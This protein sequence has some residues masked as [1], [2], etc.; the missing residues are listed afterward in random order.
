MTEVFIARAARPPI[1]GF[2]SMFR[3]VSAADLHRRQP[4]HRHRHPE[5]LTFLFPKI[6]S[7]VNCPGPD[8]GQEGA[9]GPQALT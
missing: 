5:G 7:G 9:E 2:Q 3:E 4:R 6:S 8:P 1:G